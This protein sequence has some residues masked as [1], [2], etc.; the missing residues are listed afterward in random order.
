VT[1]FDPTQI[2]PDWDAQKATLN[3]MYNQGLINLNAKKGNLMS[4]YGF[5]NK[6]NFDTS[7]N[8]VDFANLQVD[9]NQ[10]YGA[11]RNELRDEAN[12]LDA[13]QNGPDRGFSGGLANQASRTAQQAVKARQTGFQQ[14]LQ[15]QLGGLNT[16]AGNDFFNYNE[17]LAGVDTN[18]KEYAGGEGLWRALNETAAPPAPVVVPGASGG[19]RTP[20][21]PQAV[22][23]AASFGYQVVKNPNNLKPQNFTNV[24]TNRQLGHIT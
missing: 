4:Q 20:L 9:P 24:S 8:A 16:E 1:A 2:A 23:N 7:G 12:T 6:G 11:Y 3:R 15:Q 21:T 10:E 18:Q 5:L 19:G 17:G 13:A 22:T 14:N